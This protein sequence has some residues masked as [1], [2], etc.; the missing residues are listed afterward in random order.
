[1]LVGGSIVSTT[2]NPR[3]TGRTRHMNFTAK[4]PPTTTMSTTHPITLAGNLLM[5]F[6]RNADLQEEAQDALE[7]ALRQIGI[8]EGCLGI[9]AGPLAPPPGF[10]WNPPACPG[11]G[12]YPD[13]WHPACPAAFP[14]APA[15]CCHSRCRC[16]WCGK[17]ADSPQSL[18]DGN[19]DREPQQSKSAGQTNL[20]GAVRNSVMAAM[21]RE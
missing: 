4:L 3:S 19:G 18:Q 9:S 16:P 14:A 11:C 20:P 12:V 5:E 6:S 7:R 15:P 2:A 8:I 21:L 1:M 13:R 17:A 10:S